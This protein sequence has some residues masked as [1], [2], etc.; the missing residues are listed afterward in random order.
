MLDRSGKEDAYLWRT[1]KDSSH[2]P[3]DRLR[4]AKA[5]GADVLELVEEDDDAPLVT[6]GHLLC[7]PQRSVERLRWIL[8]GSSEIE[9]ELDVLA[10]ILPR[11][12]RCRRP[13]RIEN[14][15]SGVK[16]IANRAA[17]QRTVAEQLEREQMSER[18][19]I[20]TLEKIDLGDIGTVALACNQSSVRH[21]CLTGP[22]RT[23][24][25]YVAAANKRHRDA[26]NVHGSPDH[27]P[28]I[29]R[30]IGREQDGAPDA[31]RITHHDILYHVYRDN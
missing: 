5:A 13:Q 27:R 6:L 20:G 18:A 25:Y 12:D 23:R 22:P 28:R 9:R 2:L 26:V 31:A 21:G 11:A 1:L 7:E 17:E 19:G 16:R 29:K 4:V 3:R 14:A 10:E 24:Q 15:L 8:L 30:M